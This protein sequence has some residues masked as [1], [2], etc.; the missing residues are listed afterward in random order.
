LILK[1]LKGLDT[2]QSKNLNYLEVILPISKEVIIKSCLLSL[3]I[4]LV[5]KIRFTNYFTV[6][7]SVVNHLAKLKRISGVTYT[8]I[9]SFQTVNNM[10][11]ASILAFSNALLD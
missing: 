4:P 5:S 2:G 9:K 7:F 3:E 11:T 10:A 6:T 8:S 1:G